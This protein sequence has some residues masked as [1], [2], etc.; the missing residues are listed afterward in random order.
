MKYTLHLF[1]L[2][3][4]LSNY[5][6]N[7]AAQNHYNVLFETSRHCLSM[8]EKAQVIEFYEQRLKNTESITLKG[9]TDNVGSE[10]NNLL[11]SEKRVQSIRDLLVGMGYNQAKI[12][13]DYMGESDP[14]NQNKSISEKKVNRRVEINWDE[15]QPE[16]QEERG[17]IHD[18]YKLLEQEEQKFCINPDRD[19]LLHLDQGTIISIPANAFN[20]NSKECLTF[21]VKE[22]YKFSDM[23][24]ENLSTVSNTILLETGEV[25]F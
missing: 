23:I 5:A 4:A 22:I 15:I 7:C 25:L 21:N 2:L 10:K 16:I 19:T 13:I 24:M 11:L 18:L 9:H 17:N 14:L 20:T 12:S 3:V 1:L 8:K 6:T